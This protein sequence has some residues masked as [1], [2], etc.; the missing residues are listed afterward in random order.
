[1][2]QIC[3]L[4]LELS[5]ARIWRPAARC[6]AGRYD[7]VF[8][9]QWRFVAG[10]GQHESPQEALAYELQDGCARRRA[11]EPAR[12]QATRHSSISLKGR[13]GG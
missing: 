1:M 4:R 6:S 7:G 9:G 2:A 11:T 13:I 3:A 10:R 8:S 5:T 12:R